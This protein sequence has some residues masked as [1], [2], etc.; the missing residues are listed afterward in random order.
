MKLKKKTR[1]Y[2]NI[3]SVQCGNSDQFPY[4]SL[5]FLWNK[6]FHPCRVKLYSHKKSITNFLVESCNASKLGVKFMLTNNFRKMNA[7]NKLCSIPNI[8]N[9]K[10]LMGL[11]VQSFQIQATL[12]KFLNP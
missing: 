11:Y 10:Y 2:V 6:F 5:N 8:N 4:Q 9:F 7:P 3:S 12:K 1:R